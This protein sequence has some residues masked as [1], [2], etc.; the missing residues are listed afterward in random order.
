MREDL[1]KGLAAFL[2]MDRRIIFVVIAAGVVV[3][4]LLPMHLSVSA[5]PPTVAFY[6]LL[7]NLRPGT[8]VVVSIDYDPAT[9]AELTPMAQAIFRHCWRRH[10]PLIVMSVDPG[11]AGLAVA[12]TD[13]FARETGARYGRDYCLLGYKAG[14]DAVILAW[15]R[16]VRLAYP[17]DYYGRSLD[18]LPVMR[19]VRSYRDVGVVISL[20]AAGYPEYWV[21]FAHERFGARLAAGVTAVMAPDY[22]P[23]LQ[24]G[25]LSGMLGGLKG[26]AE[27]ETLIG[28]P[29]D[30]MRGMDAQA[31]VHVAVVALI[32][33]GNVAYFFIRRLEGGRG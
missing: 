2:A 12:L 6:E 18:A 10:L 17:T 32:L 8:P 29:G 3:P 25:Q 19:G 22:Y 28:R 30:G 14:I 33:L 9:T 1:R 31:A 11:G 4:T 13:G 20:A 7:E 26:A 16:N 24:T 15:G 21:A 23:F 27:Y 5:S